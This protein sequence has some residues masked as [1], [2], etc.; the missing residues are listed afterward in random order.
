[1]AVARELEKKYIV[2]IYMDARTCLTVESIVHKVMSSL[3]LHFKQSELEYFYQWMNSHEQR[4]LFLF[5]NL[6]LDPSNNCQLSEL[7]DKIIYN[8]KNARILSTSHSQFYRGQVSQE[9]YRV[10]DI[11]QSSQEFLQDMIPDCHEEGVSLLTNAV[12]HILFGLKVCGQAFFITDVDT[13]SLFEQL[14]SGR[15]DD[16]ASARLDDIIS[17]LTNNDMDAQHIIKMATLI[18]N[19]LDNMPELCMK[20]V[21]TMSNIPSDFDLSVVQS[22]VEAESDDIDVAIK[23]LVKVGLFLEDNSRYCIPRLVRVV[24]ETCWPDDGSM[25]VKISQY[26]IDKLKALIQQYHSSKSYEAVSDM[27]KDFDN[28]TAILRWVVE[29]EDTYDT[30][31]SFADMEYA[32]F[33][34]ETLPSNLYEDL[35]ESLS[36]QAGENEDILTRTN[37]LCCSSYKCMQDKNFENARAYAENAYET[38]HAAQMDENDKAFCI[39]CLGKAYW[40]DE[41]RQE[42]GLTLVKCALDNYKSNG[43]LHSVKALYA[44]EEYGKLLHAKDCYQKARHI[45]NVSDLMLTELLDCHPMLISGYDCRR[46]IWDKFFLFARSSEIAQK[47]VDTSR[48]CYGDHPLTA[49]MLNNMCECIMKRGSLQDGVS[50]AVDALTIRIKVLGDHVDTGL[51]YKLLAHLMMRTGQYDEAVRFAQSGLDVYE[52]VDAPEKHKI[53]IQNIMAQARFKLEHRSSQY[54]QISSRNASKTNIAEENQL[55]ANPNHVSTEV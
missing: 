42:K 55:S 19:V 49:M 22:F 18:R 3:G 26:Y 45:F 29:R 32:I 7:F 15:C 41:G 50:F 48:R 17:K 52:T 14:S 27:H 4:L 39:L 36:Q 30:C 25:M 13:G 47:A 2:T 31:A 11:R 38:M 34:S 40:H 12:D 5:D 33:L 51:S 1:M 53:E 21:S 10:G 35:Y 6:E 20:L 9:T 23:E 54:I 37:A 16:M 24:A 44:N 28:I 8:V 43:G 46:Q